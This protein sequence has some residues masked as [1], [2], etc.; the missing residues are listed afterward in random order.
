MHYRFISAYSDCAARYW[1]EGLHFSVISVG[2]CTTFSMSAIEDMT[3]S[4]FVIDR[5]LGIHEHENFV[6]V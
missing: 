6:N 2:G 4:D 1:A 3:K 5:R